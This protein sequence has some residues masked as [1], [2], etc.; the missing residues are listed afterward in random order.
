MANSKQT[1]EQDLMEANRFYGQGNYNEAYVLYRRCLEADPNQT[2]CLCN[3]ASLFVDNGDNE[4]AEYYY[5]KALLNDSNHAG[6][7]YNLALLLHDSRKDGYLD[8]TKNF[9][10]KLLS[11]EPSNKDA[12]ANLG[13]VFHQI[14]DL[15]AAIESYEKAIGLYRTDETN[16]A[17][18]VLSS[19][20]EK[21]GRAVLRESELNDDGDSKKNLKLKAMKALRDAL[22]FNPDNEVASHILNSQSNSQIKTAPANF[23][24]QLFDDYSD[25]FEKSLKNLEYNV[26]SLIAGKILQIHEKYSVVVD[27]GCGTGLVGPLL[28]GQVEHIIGVDLSAKMLIVAE[29]KGVYNH[30][31]IGDLTIFLIEMCHL[32]YHTKDHAKG[33]VHRKMSGSIMKDVESV[34]SEGFGGGFLGGPD[35]EVLSLTGLPLVVCAADVFVYIGDLFP[36]FSAFSKLAVKSDIFI[37]TVEENIRQEAIDVSLNGDVSKFKDDSNIKPSQSNWILQT[38]GRFAHSKGY[39]NSLVNMFENL[40]II[41]MVH[42]VPRKEL[43]VEIKGLLVAIICQ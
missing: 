16:E 3:L 15:K 28:S 39:V 14:G 4:K 12:W 10:V 8:N 31:F 17:K 35:E 6:A 24:K 20:Y 33:N 19:L 41:S 23:V 43:G 36:I 34:V 5:K 40:G 37:F 18:I 42:I 30:L 2:D 7:L 29:E 38:S 32:R 1:V 13:A 25:S 21:V 9:Y 27:L 11:I 22:S 26:P